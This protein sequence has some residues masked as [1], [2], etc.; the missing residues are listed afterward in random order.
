MKKLE[1][2]IQHVEEY[3]K[4]DR[5][6]DQELVLLDWTVIQLWGQDI[7][8]YMECCLQVIEEAVFEKMIADTIE[9]IFLVM[10]FNSRRLYVPN[11]RR[12]FLDK[13][14]R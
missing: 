13:Y 12:D 5:R 6:V 11:L 14:I 9:L 2:W 1:Y 8:K 4:C 10:I 7:N 3:M